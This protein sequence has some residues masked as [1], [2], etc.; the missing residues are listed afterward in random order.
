MYKGIDV[1]AW[2]GDIDYDKLNVDFVIIRAG[3]GQ[4]TIDK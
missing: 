1:S 2:Q 4:K 3:H